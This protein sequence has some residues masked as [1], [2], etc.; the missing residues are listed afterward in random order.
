M[1][2][3]Y[4]NRSHR[5]KRSTGRTSSRSE[6]GTADLLR[7]LLLRCNPDSNRSPDRQSTVFQP[8][9][10]TAPFSPKCF[11]GLCKA[12]ERPRRWHGCRFRAGPRNVTLGKP[13]F[14]FIAA[15]KNATQY[16]PH[17]NLSIKRHAD[18]MVDYEF[19]RQ[20]LYRCVVTSHFR[21]A[22]RTAAYGITPKS[23][24]NVK[25]SLVRSSPSIFA[26]VRAIR[27]PR[28]YRLRII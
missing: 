25:K 26:F 2:R 17:R 16:F 27:S 20:L 11:H 9:V 6:P 15:L 22:S 3:V 12:R 4:S 10:T 13:Q 23:D 21:M 18:Y 28:G 1:G 19:N 24:A 8:S 14:E 7:F 5:Q